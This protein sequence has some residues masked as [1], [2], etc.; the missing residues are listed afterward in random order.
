MA[1][2]FGQGFTVDVVLLEL[3]VIVRPTIPQHAHKCLAPWTLSTPLSS[4]GNNW[5]AEGVCM[6]ERFIDC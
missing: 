5:P 4:H 3:L 2:A 6:P 1:F